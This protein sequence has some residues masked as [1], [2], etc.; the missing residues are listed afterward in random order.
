MKPDPSRPRIPL[1]LSNTVLACAAAA[2]A[3]STLAPP[4]T[5]AQEKPALTVE[6]YGRWERLG[7]ATLSPN[8][9]W[10]AVGISR[11]NDEGELRIHSTDSDSVVVVPFATRPVFSSDNRWLAY[12]IGVSPD[13]RERM[14]KQKKPVRNKLG[15]LDLG[16]G[17]QEDR[18]RHPVVLVLGGRALHRAAALQARRQEERRLWTWWCASSRPGRRS[19]W[20]NVAR[21]SWR[22]EGH[23]LAMTIDADDQVGNGVRLYDPGERGGCG[24]STRTRRRTATWGW[25]EDAA[26]LVVLKTYTDDDHEDTAHVALAWRDLDDDDPRA[27]VLDPREGG[28]T[29]LPQGMRVVEHRR[30]SWSEDGRTI[31]LGLQDRTPVEKDEGDAEG[32]GEEEEGEGGGCRG[33]GRGG[34]CGRR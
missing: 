31:F 9:R 27:F 8:G 19:A 7:G 34:R 16:T 18:R 4:A 30:P 26:D 20:G 2:L 32:Q 25:R 10:A 1:P 33:G 14:R 29:L 11:V 28:G 17:E 22:D 6:D 5:R 24:L 3:A 23:L 13:E 21:M 12:S 15:L